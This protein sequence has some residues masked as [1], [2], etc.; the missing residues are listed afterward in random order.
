MK[1]TVPVPTIERNFVAGESVYTYVSLYE[2]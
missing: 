1:I 2:I